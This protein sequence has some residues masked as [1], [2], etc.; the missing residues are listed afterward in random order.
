ML[1]FRTSGAQQVYC[2]INFLR[3]AAWSSETARSASWNFR[4]C[5]SAERAAENRR[6]VRRNVNAS[7]SALENWVYVFR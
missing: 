1:F 6:P 3:M 2:S 7:V 4:Y 5:G